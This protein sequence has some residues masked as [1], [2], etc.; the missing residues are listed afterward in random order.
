MNIMKQVAITLL[1]TA[2]KLEKLAISCKRACL[3]S[4]FLC[5]KRVVLGHLRTRRSG[6]KYLCLHAWKHGRS[7]PQLRLRRLGHLE[8]GSELLEELLVTIPGLL[9]S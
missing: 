3:K 2:V 4:L 7:L 1:W 9:S 5:V 8:A 6:A